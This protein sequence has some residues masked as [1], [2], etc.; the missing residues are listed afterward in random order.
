MTG[1]LVLSA[2]LAQPA[3]PTVAEQVN[4]KTVKLFGAGGFRGVVSYGT[5]ILISAD[6]HILTAAAQMLDT[7]ELIV[8]LSDGRK[9]KAQVL[10]TE[11]ELDAALVQINVEGKKPGWTCRISISPPRPNGPAPSPAIGCWGS[12]I[13]SKSPCVTSR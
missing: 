11:P 7:S 2:I 10:V 9:M 12:A 13:A 1:V 8:H 3:I 6:G 4:A 5:G